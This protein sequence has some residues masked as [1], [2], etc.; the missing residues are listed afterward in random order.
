M[1]PGDKIR[2]ERTERL[3]YRSVAGTRSGVIHRQW[4]AF[5][6]LLKRY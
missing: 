5:E 1:M 6:A 3:A 4:L 2:N